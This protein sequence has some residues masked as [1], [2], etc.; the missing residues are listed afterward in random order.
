M[1]QL[2]S[3]G[4]LGFTT[5]AI[6][7]WPML[8]EEIFGLEA[9]PQEDGSLRL[10]WDDRA[11]RL[12]LFPG[13]EDRIAF[14]GW[15]VRDEQDLKEFVAHLESHGIEVELAPEEDR[16]ARGVQHLVRFVDPFGVP[17]ELFSGQVYLDRTFKGGRATSGFI[18]GAQGAGHF[19]LA[20]PSLEEAYGFYRDVLGFRVSDVVDMG[21]GTMS[22]LRL[23]PRHH[24]LALWEVPGRVGLNHIMVESKD[25]DDVGRAYDLLQRS[26]YTL[27]STLGRHTGDEQLSFYT[28]TPSGFDL[29]FGADS[30]VIEEEQAWTVRYYGKEFGSH[31]EIWGHKW[32]PLPPQS[33]IHPYGDGAELAPMPGPTEGAQ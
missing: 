10:R 7:E 5:P 29:E 26:D 22:F 31:N 3:F 20:V 24:S 18:T 9:Y 30:L 12:Q 15:E 6:R 33:S 25:I 13:H 32:Q 17:Q 1:A 14:I 28:R 23:N 4:Y 27:S 16:L 2:H 21:F 11:F 19:V 8:A